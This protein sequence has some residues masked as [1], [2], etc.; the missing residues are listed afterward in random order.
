MKQEISIASCT[1]KRGG[2]A[3]A[4]ITQLVNPTPT[5]PN[6]NSC[7]YV[8]YWQNPPAHAV[9]FR[10]PH[11]HLVLFHTNLD[12]IVEAKSIHLHGRGHDRPNQ[13]LRRP[14]Q[15]KLHLLHACQHLRHAYSTVT[16]HVCARAAGELKKKV[17]YDDSQAKGNG[18]ASA[19]HRR[20]VNAKV[21]CCDTSAQTLHHYCQIQ[22]K[23]NQR[24]AAVAFDT[25]NKILLGERRPTGPV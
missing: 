16:L 13:L 5:R 21:C 19:H 15:G 14:V 12:G 4:T 17:R 22:A 9:V 6:Q 2:M 7:R 18:V 10:A 20:L 1:R 25:N 3:A 8:D 24:V 11:L 23:R